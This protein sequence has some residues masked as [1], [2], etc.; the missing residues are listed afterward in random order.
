MRQKSALCELPSETISE[1]APVGAPASS[2]GQPFVKHSTKLPRACPC[3][4][5]QR[6]REDC[7]A[8]L[9]ACLSQHNRFVSDCKDKEPDVLFVG[10]SM[11]QLLQQY[12]VRQESRGRA[13]PSGCF[14]NPVTDGRV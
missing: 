9:A 6:D 10:D 2:N 5:Q 12:E 11:V 14:F 8:H 1:N 3:L 13:G 7:Q 4:P